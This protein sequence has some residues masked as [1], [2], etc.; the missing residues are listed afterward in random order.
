MISKDGEPLEDLET[1]FRLAGPKHDNQWQD[2]R[3]AKEAARAS[4]ELAPGSLPTEI[5]EALLSHEDLGQL[6]EWS[7]EPEARVFFDSFGGE[8]ANLDLMVHARDGTGSLVIA[9]EAKADEPFGATL[10]E[11]ARAASKRKAENPR[12]KGL[13]RLER[14]AETVLGVPGDEM[15][16]IDTLRYQLLTATAAAVAEAQRRSVSRAVLL[17]HEFVTEQTLDEKHERNA[18]DLDAFVRHISGG[19]IEG[20]EAGTVCGPFQLPG[21]GEGDST[22]RFYV[23]KG[24]RNLRGGDASE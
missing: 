17:I 6:V 21:G 19:G 5:L 13:D 12:S 4:I 24:V 7:A 10:S 11:T 20:V 22:V 15:T 8:P 3:S 18:A 9:V 2:G 1:W 16:G 14:L 23:G